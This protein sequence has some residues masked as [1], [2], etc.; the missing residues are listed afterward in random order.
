M[1][2]PLL[3]ASPLLI[4]AQRLDQTTAQAVAD[5]LTSYLNVPSMSCFL[6]ILRPLIYPTL[7]LRPFVTHTIVIDGCISSASLPPNSASKNLAAL[8]LRGAFHD[9]GTWDPKDANGQFGG[10]DGTLTTMTD[11][12]E[13]SGLMGSTADLFA[14]VAAK[15]NIDSV[16]KADTIAMAG[17]IAVKHCG[18]PDIPYRGGRIDGSLQMRHL[19]SKLPLPSDCIDT[20]KLKFRRME[21]TNGEIVAISMSF[22]FLKCLNAHTHL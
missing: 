11:A 2:L 18:G 13:H 16:S 1:L 9:A 21:F 3:L 12:G 19:L 15:I 14:R 6:F 7:L 20:I 8:W 10:A 5:A 22:F 4:T 17:Q